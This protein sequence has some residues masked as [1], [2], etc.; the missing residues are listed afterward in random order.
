[1]L[2]APPPEREQVPPACWLAGQTAFGCASPTPCKV[3]EK[4]GREGLW[5]AQ[6]GRADESQPCQ[7]PSMLCTFQS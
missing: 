4:R 3:E 5:W 7:G 1:M 2:T 6:D